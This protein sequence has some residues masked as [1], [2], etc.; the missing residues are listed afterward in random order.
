[1]RATTSPKGL[2]NIDDFLQTSASVLL[3]KTFKV[4][5]AVELKRTRDNW[6]V[7]FVC[8]SVCRHAHTCEHVVGSGRGVLKLE[9]KRSGAHI[10]QEIR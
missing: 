4:I 5:S 8:E 1:M 7:L 10:W 3:L 6:W 2:K 9:E